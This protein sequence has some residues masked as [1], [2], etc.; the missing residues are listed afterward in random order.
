MGNPKRRISINAPA[1]ITFVLIVFYILLNLLQVGGFKFINS[2]NSLPVAPLAAATTVLAILLWWKI[3]R[4]DKNRALWLGLA[5]GW[6]LWT[7][8]EIYWAVAALTLNEVPYPSIADL[9]WV[10][11]YLPMYFALWKRR[12]SLPRVVS[13]ARRWLIALVSLSIL[14]LT[15]VFII[16]PGVQSFDPSTF[17]ESVLNVTYPFLDIILLIVVFNLFFTYEQGKSGQAWTW[18]LMGFVMFSA[19]D[20]VFSFANSIN[21]YYPEE[22]VNL[23]STLGIDVPYTL[24]YV[25]CIVGLLEFRK[26]QRLTGFFQEVVRTETPLPNTHILVSTIRDNTVVDVSKNYQVSYQREFIKGQP[27]AEVLGITTAETNNLLETLKRQDAM[28]ESQFQATIGGQSIPIGISGIRVTGSLG[29]FD[30]VILLVRLYMPYTALD[31]LLTDYEKDM[32]RSLL[33]KTGTLERERS[34]MKNFLARYHQ[35]FLAEFLGVAISEGGKAMVESL[36]AGLNEMCANN[37]WKLKTLP[38]GSFDV[39]AS[40]FQETYSALPQLVNKARQ[41]IIGIKDES[42]AIN[43]ILDVQKKEDETS[44]KNLAYCEKYNAL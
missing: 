12:S 26:L 24:S 16:V 22:Q 8:A 37:Q 18:L 17:I 27:L 34:E 1:I 15:I 41:F 30:G 33:Q 40:S 28:M 25:M 13:T 39:N 5:I 10:L 7:I 21:M 31:G 20:L 3:P 23:L 44:L 9:M 32:V 43:V 2:L 29:E 38:N 35:R 42:T 4:E 6:S 19:V 36:I 14:A 11:G